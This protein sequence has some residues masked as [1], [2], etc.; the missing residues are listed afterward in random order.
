MVKASRFFLNYVERGL[1]NIES[2]RQRSG[3]PSGV[4]AAGAWQSWQKDQLAIQD[5]TKR[6]RERERGDFLSQES[7][8]MEGQ[9]KADFAPNFPLPSH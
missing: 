9:W 7:I 8:C 4:A 1:K 6:E 5:S 2:E 3:R